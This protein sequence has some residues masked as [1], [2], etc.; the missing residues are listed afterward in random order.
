MVAKSRRSR[1]EDGRFVWR[2]RAFKCSGLGD[3]PCAQQG[4]AHDAI[5]DHGGTVAPRFSAVR[6][7]GRKLA[8]DVAVERY[9][10]VTQTL[11]RTET[12]EAG[13]RQAHPNFPLAL[14]TTGPAPQPPSFRS[15]VSLTWSGGSCRRNLQLDLLATQRSVIGQGRDF[16]ERAA[17]LTASTNAD[18][19]TD[20]VPLAPKAARPSRSGRFGAVTCQQFGPVFGDIGELGFQRLAIRHGARAPLADDVP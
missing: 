15:S 8:H 20:G 2:R 16:G 7:L 6:G 17:L 11:Y 3:L 1:A 12:T 13:L 19:A 5:P 18:R 14:G 9:V 10:T 4:N